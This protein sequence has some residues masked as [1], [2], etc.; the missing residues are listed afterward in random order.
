[1]NITAL[2]NWQLLILKETS[3]ISG[4][5]QFL[6]TRDFHRTAITLLISKVQQPFSYLYPYSRFPHEVE[7]WDKSGKLVN[8]FSSSPLMDNLPVEGVPTGRR[9]YGWIPSEPATLIWAEALDGGNTRA[10]ITPRDKVMKLAAPFSG[11]PSEIIK[12]EQ[13][14]AGRQFG[15]K[16]GTMF[17]S[18]INRDTQKRKLWLLDY[19]NP[20]VA[21]KVVSDLNVNDRYNDIGSFVNK[22]L[23]NGFQRSDA[24]W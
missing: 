4:S 23:P 16:P 12:T 24:R 15:E 20:S 18:E 19:K 8:K 6:T 9:S 10:K 13:R 11:E 22:R 2:L 1:M 17:L 5:Q 3:R 21:P 7:I 14:Y